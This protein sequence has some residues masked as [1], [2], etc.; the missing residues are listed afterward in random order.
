MEK[1]NRKALNTK[2]IKQAVRQIVSGISRIDAKEFEDEV[3]IRDEL[4][5]DSLM[6]MEIIAT[7]EK[8]L[9]IQIDEAKFSEIETVGDFLDLV[10]DLYRKTHQ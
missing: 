9:D 5:I 4:G 7:C 10:I 2:E 6:A 3:I 1:H 8:H